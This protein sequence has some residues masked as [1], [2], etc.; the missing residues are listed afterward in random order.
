MFDDGHVRSRRVAEFDVLE[1]D[2][3]LN[4]LGFESSRISGVDVRDSVDGLEKLGSSATSMGDSLHLWSKE[5][6]REGTDDDGKK[7]IYDGTRG[8]CKYKLRSGVKAINLRM[9]APWCSLTSVV[10]KEKARA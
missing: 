4:V 5:G 1:G 10:P 8:S 3:T 2:K 7:Y 9:D 6:Q